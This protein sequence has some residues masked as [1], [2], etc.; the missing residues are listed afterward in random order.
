MGAEGSGRLGKRNNPLR[1]LPRCPS[2]QTYSYPA[3]STDSSWT[4]SKAG[5][6]RDHSSRLS[7]VLRQGDADLCSYMNSTHSTSDCLFQAVWWVAAE[8]DRLSVRWRAHLGNQGITRM[9]WNTEQSQ[10][11]RPGLISLAGSPGAQYLITF[12]SNISEMKLG[13]WCIFCLADSTG[14]C[15]LSIFLSSLTPPSRFASW[16]ANHPLIIARQCWQGSDLGLSPAPTTSIR[17]S[18]LSLLLT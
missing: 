16:L 1:R 17:H 4:D 11:Y 2:G 6:L 8:S 9:S 18:N 3:G 15:P 5:C 7:P 10:G 12:C 14:L 13:P